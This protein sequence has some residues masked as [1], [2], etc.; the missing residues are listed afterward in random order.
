MGDIAYTAG[1]SELLDTVAPLWEK[2]RRQHE[3]L[4]VHFADRLRVYGFDARREGLLHKTAEGG[5][6]VDLA[7][8]ADG[9]RLVGYAIATVTADR[10]GE[11]ESL[12]VEPAFRHRGV[13][14]HLMRLSLAWLDARGAD[15]QTL[16]VACGNEMV[17]DFYRRHGFYPLSTLLRRKG[18]DGRL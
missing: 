7:R 6:R 13:G 16:Y 18:L 11:V 17:F 15:P 12:Y 5:L 1:G 4:S 10:V 3:E 8:E 2:L 14:D 9:D